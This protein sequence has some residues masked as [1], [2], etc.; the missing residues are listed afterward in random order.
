[1]FGILTHLDFLPFIL[2]SI[3]SF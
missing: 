2:G 3:K 1:M